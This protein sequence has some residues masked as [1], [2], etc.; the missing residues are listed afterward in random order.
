MNR[1]SGTATPLVTHRSYHSSVASDAHGVISGPTLTP[2]SRPSSWRVVG[3]GD[4]R[5]ARDVRREV[6][7]QVRQARPGQRGPVHARPTPAGGADQV[8]HQGPE[9]VHADRLHHEEQPGD[10]H[11]QPPR[12]Q[13]PAQR[14][15]L[16][17]GERDQHRERRDG[18]GDAELH[19]AEDRRDEE[20]A[21]GP[22]DPEQPLVGLARAAPAARTGRRRAGRAASRTPTGTRASPRARRPAPGRAARRTQRGTGQPGSPRAGSSGSTPAA[23]ATRCSPARP[24]TWPAAAARRPASA[25]APASPG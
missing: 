6:V 5:L 21:R 17:D 12:Q 3:D 20:H 1:R 2:I 9:Q 10:E 13:P 16:P 24:C 18:R 19:P 8:R 11:R 22:G 7:D 4:H 15:P 23:A 25:P 14:R